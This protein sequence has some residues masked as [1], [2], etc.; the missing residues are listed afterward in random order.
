[1]IGGWYY[2]SGYKSWRDH[3]VGELVA[4]LGELMGNEDSWHDHIGEIS[5]EFLKR[6]A[7]KVVAEVSVEAQLSTGG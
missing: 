7:F 5:E 6:V 2:A 1:M 3:T 4:L